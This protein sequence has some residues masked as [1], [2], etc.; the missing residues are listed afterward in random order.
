MRKLSASRRFGATKL[1]VV[2]NGQASFGTIA[3][4]ENYLRPD[5]LLVMNLSGTI[6]GSFSVKK[7]GSEESFEI[8][9]AAFAG[10]SL[11]DLREW[12]AITFG[13][14]DWHLPTEERGPPPALRE[15]DILTASSKLRLQVRSVEQGSLLRIAFLGEN[16]LS[17]LY[18]VASPI[19]YSYQE[20]ELALW[21]V[22]TS[23]S[24]LPLSVEA[25]SALFPFDWRK[26]LALKGKVE[27]AFLYHGAGISSA[28]S[29]ALDERLPLPE[30]YSIPPATVRAWQEAR[31]M[32]GR[33]IAIGTSVA[34]ALESA[35]HI[36]QGEPRLIEGIT[37]LRVKAG[38]TM[39]RVDG[40]LTGYHDPLTSHFDLEAAFVGA[41]ALRNAF[42][43]A[44]ALQF[45]KHEFG[46]AT[47]LFRG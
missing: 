22:Q 2:D 21:D 39:E 30:F 35:R 9:L 5:D 42:S 11:S 1:M 8:R 43:Q 40:M 4:L 12:W 27:M 31:A 26:L 17:E 28:G 33:V 41:E 20:K 44:E 19:Q 46:D 18:R 32:G 6:P 13:S 23:L 36:G 45:R 29:A 47:L 10:S 15:G 14:G 37:T 7:E 24:Q 38:C 16:F 25:P 3:D 34:R